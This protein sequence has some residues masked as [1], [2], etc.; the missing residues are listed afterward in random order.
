MSFVPEQMNTLQTGGITLL[1]DVPRV[2]DGAQVFDLMLET[3][4]NFASALDGVLVDDKRIPLSDAATEKIRAELCAILD[5]M[6]TAQ[7]AAGSPRAL[8]L[9]S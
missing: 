8:R 7:I 4:R 5:K 1:L 2:S 3:A 9:F 6:G